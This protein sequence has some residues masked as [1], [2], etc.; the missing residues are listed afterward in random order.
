MIEVNNI[1]IG[2]Q[3]LPHERHLNIMLDEKLNCKIKKE[4][5]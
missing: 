2:E 1:E 5:V 4:M 3:H